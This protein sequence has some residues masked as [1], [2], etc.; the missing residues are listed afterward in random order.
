MSEGQAT[1]DA[2]RERYGH[3]AP[4]VVEGRTTSCEPATETDAGVAADIDG[5]SMSAFVRARKPDA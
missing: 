1:K 3:A 5:R 2:V 4:Q